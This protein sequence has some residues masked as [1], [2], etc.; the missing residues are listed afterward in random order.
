MCQITNSNSINWEGKICWQG[1]VGAQHRALKKDVPV[2]SKSLCHFKCSSLKSEPQ[3][4][5]RSVAES[6]RSWCTCFSSSRFSHVPVQFRCKGQVRRLG[7]Q[8]G[9]E[10]CG[11]LGR[12]ALKKAFLH[13]KCL[14]SCYLIYVW[15]VPLQ[16]KQPEGHVAWSSPP[17]CA[18]HRPDTD[19]SC[20]QGRY[21]LFL[22]VFK[23][24][25]SC[26]QITF[27]YG[28][29]W[30]SPRSLFFRGALQPLRQGR[31]LWPAPRGPTCP[32]ARAALLSSCT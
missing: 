2:F 25:S 17:S 5:R 27:A 21:W 15:H 3:Q 13:W 16:A 14:C 4:T 20:F 23:E 18:R 8:P 30:A 31:T 28:I 1:R 32:L 7:I 22:L 19:L 12:W 24:N 10:V 26:W 9:R 29:C 6:G 11:Q